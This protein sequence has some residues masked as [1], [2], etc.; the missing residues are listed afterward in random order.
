MPAFVRDGRALTWAEVAR[1]LRDDAALRRQLTEA[2]A[3]SHRALL[4]ECVPVSRATRDQPFEHVLLDCPALRDVP[5]DPR[6]FAPHLA[7][8]ASIATF[9]NLGRDARLVAP[10]ALGPERHYPHLA[11]FVRGAPRDQVHELWAAV[12]ASVAR[13][14]AERDTPVWVSTC[15]LGVYWLHVRLDQR[16][17]Y[18]T[19]TPFRSWSEGGLPTRSR[20]RPP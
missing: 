12:G 7:A 5:P 4:W 1:G 3:A 20:V 15:G 13:W 2:I 8:V 11:A 19:W 10:R 16:P 9:D 14:W 18:I 17:K 6:P